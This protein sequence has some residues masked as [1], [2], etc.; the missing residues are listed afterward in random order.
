MTTNQIRKMYSVAQNATITLLDFLGCLAVLGQ[1]AKSTAK[2]IDY[3]KAEPDGKGNYGK[4]KSYG[5]SDTI[6]HF[7]GQ[8]F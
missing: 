7:F 5:G 4:F 1:G 2:I 8:F 3:Y 6:F